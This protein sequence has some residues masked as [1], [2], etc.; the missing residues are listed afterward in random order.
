MPFLRELT[1]ND[2]SS[3]FGWR[4]HPVTKEWKFHEGVDI[5]A[6]KENV[7]S[8]GKGIVKKVGYH[9]NLGNYVLIDHGY[10]ETQYQ[11]LYTTLVKEGQ[12]VDR[13]QLIAVSGNTGM[14]TGYHLHF[15]IKVG[16]RWVDP[17]LFEQVAKVNIT[18]D[19][20]EYKGLISYDDG[21]S[22]IETR[23]FGED[24]GHTV[25][26]E[27]G[28]TIILNGKNKERIDEIIKKLEDLRKSL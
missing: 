24:L 3:P 22:Y 27:D 8:F 16:G 11:H 14:S 26:W 18:A 2:I 5:K 15:G 12:A 23:A 7:Y 17:M 19:G 21:K 13:K 28:V 25:L 10:C 20:K 4:E 1:K 9:N 6:F